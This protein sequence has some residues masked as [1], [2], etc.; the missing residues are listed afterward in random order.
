DQQGRLRARDRLGSGHGPR[1]GIVA[2]EEMEEAPRGFEAWDS[3]VSPLYLA[4]SET[5]GTTASRG[6][7]RSRQAAE[8]AGSPAYRDFAGPVR[9]RDP[10]SPGCSWSCGILEV[11]GFPGHREGRLA[12]L[13]AGSTG[14]GPGDHMG[15]LIRA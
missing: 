12:G 4:V 10:G 7:L 5:S 3:R 2:G 1:A 6:G 9:S 15:R 14:G 13:A 8:A 11:A